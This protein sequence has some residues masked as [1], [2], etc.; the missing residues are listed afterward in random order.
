MCSI[1]GALG[2]LQNVTDKAALVLKA[3]KITSTLYSLNYHH[4]LSCNPGVE[5]TINCYIG[6]TIYPYGAK[7]FLLKNSEIAVIIEH[8][9]AHSFPISACSE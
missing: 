9:L 1:H 7:W 8:L 5:R 6:R 4:S 3:Q 2:S